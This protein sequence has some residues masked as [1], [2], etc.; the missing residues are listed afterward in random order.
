MKNLILIFL[1]SLIVGISY[2]QETRLHAIQIHQSS[3]TDGQAL[4]WN[5]TAD[6]WEAQSIS[7]GTDDQQISLAGN[8]LTLENGGTVDLSGYL[9]NTDDQ[10]LSLAGDIL[11]LED[12]GTVDLSQYADNTDE[13][14]L[15]YNATTG[16]LSISDGNTVTIDIGA[17]WVKENVEVSVAGDTY[18]ISNSVSP[19]QA[20]SMTISRNGLMQR[21]GN[22]SMDV[23]LSGTTLTFNQR[24]LEIGEIL[25]IQYAK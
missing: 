12:G 4:I 20:A 25:V 11:T 15:S 19:A 8:T 17:L 22:S 10:Q 9:D 21:I 7:T 1:L 14:M 6:K 2:G 5:N 24:D 18:T 16:V 23:S 13:Q 3:A